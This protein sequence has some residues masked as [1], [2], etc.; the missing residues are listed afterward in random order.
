[1]GVKKAGR[2]GVILKRVRKTA[3]KAKAGASKLSIKKM[4]KHK[5]DIMGYAMTNLKWTTTRDR[6]EETKAQS[7]VVKA[8]DKR[9]IKQ[10]KATQP[11]INIH[12]G[13][14]KKKLQSARNHYATKKNKPVHTGK[15][16]RKPA[17]FWIPDETRG[18]VPAALERKIF[19][20]QQEVIIL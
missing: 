15:K 8:G 11:E 2:R 20:K 13:D 10:L 19:T 5:N 18:A 9:A 1:M 16:K 3:Q 14:N 6:L 12:H 17:A 4:E 7:A